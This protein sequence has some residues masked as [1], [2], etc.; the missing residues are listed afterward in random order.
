MSYRQLDTKN[1]IIIQLTKTSMKSHKNLIVWQKSMMLVTRIYEMTSTFPHEE[2]FGI[3]SQM[4]RAA[5]S[6]PSNIAEGY[7][8][9]YGKET[10]K[11]LS[12]ALGSASELETQLEI[13]FRLGF[14]SNIDLDEL[15]NLTNEILR[16]LAALIKTVD[17]SISLKTDTEKKQ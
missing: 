12:N 16:M 10:L 4:R 1:I 8:R 5:V 14:G 13:C 11:F 2:L 7:G 9:V 3:T 17:P 6:I 15:R